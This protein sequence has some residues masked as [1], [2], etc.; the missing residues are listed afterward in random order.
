MK[1]IFFISFFIVTSVLSGQTLDTIKCYNAEELRR[2]AKGLIEKNQYDSLL[3]IT[4]LENQ[5]LYDVIYVKDIILYN[6][7]SI[8]KIQ[9]LKL[10]ELEYRYNIILSDKKKVDKKNNYLVVGLLVSL[11]ANIA[12]FT[13]R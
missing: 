8:L 9:N 2:I 12:F 13:T 3:E 6:T 10:S 4:T 11:F 5:S 7:D 1:K